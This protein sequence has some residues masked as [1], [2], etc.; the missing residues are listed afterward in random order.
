MPV[1]EHPLLEQPSSRRRSEFL[2]AV[3][4]S[5]ELHA[6]WATPAATDGEFDEYLKRLQSNSHLGYWVCTA[7]GEL[8]GVI[9]VTEI[10]RG[11]FCSAYLGYYAFVP[12]NRRGYMTR[13]LQAVVSETFGTYLLH[14]LEANIQPDNEA[15]RRL[16][17]RLGFRL[18]GFSPRYLM[19]AGRWRDHER[20]ALTAEDWSPNR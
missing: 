14:R 7:R 1:I 9:N 3:T 4:R 8:A 2:D 6:H 10:V 18:E 11:S 17:Q 15:S 13:A 5:R 12:H 19:V 20:W 16:V